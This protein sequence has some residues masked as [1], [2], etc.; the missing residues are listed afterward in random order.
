MN[1]RQKLKRTSSSLAFAV[2][3]FAVTASSAYAFGNQ[4]FLTKA[5]LNDD[6][7]V[8][9]QEARELHKLGDFAGA[10]DALMSAGFDE[11]TLSDLRQAHQTHQHSQRHWI[12]Q[13]IA[14]KLTDEQQ[15]ALQVAREANDRQTMRA[16]LSEAGIERP[17]RE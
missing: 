3:A 1:R 9:I 16:I 5:G 17:D 15:D 14:E 8:A 2:A 10:R 4:A 13:Q 12:K 11:A 7:V 6:Q